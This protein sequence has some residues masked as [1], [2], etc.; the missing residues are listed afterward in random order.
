MSVMHGAKALMGKLLGA[1]H[2]GDDKLAVNKVEA[3]A[4]ITVESPA[5]GNG[6]AMGKKYTQEGENVSPPLTW[7]GVPANAAEVVLV[8]EDPDAPHPQ[9]VLH[10]MA[11]RIPPE[12]TELKEGVSTWPEIPVGVGPGKMMRQGAN[13]SKKVGYTGPM[14]PVGHGVHHYH[15]QVFAVDR[16]LNVSESPEREQLIAAMKGHVVAQGELVGTYER[17]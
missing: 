2:A 13:V 12:V 15:F 10:W 9:P 1:V 4:V 6:G 11:Y 8:V 16:V 7:K 5:F 3:P 17:K 14:P